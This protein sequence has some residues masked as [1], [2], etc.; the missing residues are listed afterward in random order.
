[1]DYLISEQLT[2]KTDDRLVELLSQDGL[3]W[4][5]QWSAIYLYYR[6]EVDVTFGVT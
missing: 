2:Q 3:L 4:L 6:S 5:S 1:M